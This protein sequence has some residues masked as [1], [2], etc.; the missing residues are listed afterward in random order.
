MANV[1]R[2]NNGGAIQ[3]RTGVL[4]GV[5]PVGPRGPRGLD[6]PEGPEGPEGARGPAGAIG[7]YQARADLVD[8]QPVASGVAINVAFAAVSYDD[9]GVF[10]SST[11]MTFEEEGD[12]LITAYVRWAVP[13]GASAGYRQLRVRSLTNSLDLW[14]ANVSGQALGDMPVTNISFPHRVITADEVIQIKAEHGDN[15]TVNVNE[16]AVVITRVGPGPVGPRGLQGIEGPEGPEG[17][18]GPQ[19]PP[20][21]A[22]TGYST[23]GAI[24]GA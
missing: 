3:V 7:K 8:A 5:G 16:G 18:P 4:A 10:T 24:D 15:E 1:I 2:L 12:Y 6:G 9:I 19:G 11:N 20:G 17:P 13:A 21:E 22:G 14:K 23:Y